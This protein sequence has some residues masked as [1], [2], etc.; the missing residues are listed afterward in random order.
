MVAIAS[1]KYQN[2]AIIAIISTLKKVF[3]FNAYWFAFNC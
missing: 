1:E 2:I 3:V